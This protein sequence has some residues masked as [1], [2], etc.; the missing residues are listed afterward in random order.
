MR[1]EPLENLVRIG[2]L[3][4]VATSPERV[5]QILQISQT[6]LQDALLDECIKQAQMLLHLALKSLL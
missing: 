5:Q 6:R 1:S 4:L 3:S 2:M